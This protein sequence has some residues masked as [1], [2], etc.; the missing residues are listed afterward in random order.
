[1]YTVHVYMCVKAILII[2]EAELAQPYPQSHA[3]PPGIGPYPSQ[4]PPS[5]DVLYTA[6]APDHD[7]QAI[8]V[9]LSLI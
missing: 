9:S 8:Q 3:N 5:Y 6:K 7:H 2:G 1:M 4:S